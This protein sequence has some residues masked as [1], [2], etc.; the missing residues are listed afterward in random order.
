MPREARDCSPYGCLPSPSPAHASRLAFH[1]SRSRIIVQ[2]SSVLIRGRAELDHELLAQQPAMATAIEA[3]PA[4]L[5]LDSG[6]PTRCSLTLPLAPDS[7]VDRSAGASS[8]DGDLQNARPRVT[9]DSVIFRVDPKTVL[10]LLCT[11]INHL[12]QHSASVPPTPPPSTPTTPNMR[13]LKLEKEELNSRLE[14]HQRRIRRRAMSREICS[15]STLGV[16]EASAAVQHG[17]VIRKFFS[18]KPPPVSLEEYVLRLQTYCAMSTAVCLAASHHIFQLAL[19]ERVLQLSELNV[20]RLVLAALRVSSK[21]LEDRT[22]AQSRFCRVGGVNENEMKHLETAFCFATNFELK[23]DQQILETEYWSLRELAAE[24]DR[25]QSPGQP[26]GEPSPET[27]L[28]ALQIG[29]S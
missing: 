22:W 23:V 4:V 21:V 10:R 29:D 19:V 12:L 6:C 13:S 28:A 2:Y 27:A 9:G 8:S 15:P 18:K 16:G 24:S 25:E 26:C 5:W 3:V 11:S 14:A 20:H 7:S 17:A 1:Y